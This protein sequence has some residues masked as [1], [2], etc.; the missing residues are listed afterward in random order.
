MPQMLS[1]VAKLVSYDKST[2]V[3]RAVSSGRVLCTKHP[4]G[5]V[6]VKVGGFDVLAH[7]LAWYIEH[8]Q[9]PKLI[10]HINRVKADNRIANL[11]EATPSQNQC[12]RGVQSNSSS[13]FTGVAKT[14]QGDK[15]QAYIKLDG[16]RSHL[17]VFAKLEDALAAR[18]SAEK[19]LMGGFA[20]LR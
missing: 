17:G 20:P 6:R 15:W 13:G 1:E 12:N 9:E 2:G 7:R 5:Y 19:E 14:R 16:K 10:D 4:R 18:Q 11:R 8:K 3:F